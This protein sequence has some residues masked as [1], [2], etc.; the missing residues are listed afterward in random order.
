MIFLQVLAG[1]FYANVIEYCVHRFL[2]HGLGKSRTSIF[3]F[4]LR[5]HHLIARRDGFIDTHFSYN[6]LIGMPV[7]V[8][9]HA[10][11][12]LLSPPFFYALAAY[13][14]LFVF[15]HNMLHRFPKF[16]Q[17]YFWW[18]WNHHMRNQNKSWGVV[19]PLTDIL[20]G[21]LEPISS[22]SEKDQKAKG[23]V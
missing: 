6:E 14:V 1:I 13:G 2:F 19:L 22:K 12:L 10:P 23:D 3:A 18:H 4:H 8:L 7:L 11:L 5:G 20:T 9:F 16:S 15:I 21:E 17:K